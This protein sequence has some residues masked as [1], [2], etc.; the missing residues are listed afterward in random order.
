MSLWR[1]LSHGVRAL[2]GGRAADREVDEE[3]RQFLDES[4]AELE[5]NGL[6][7]EE[8]ARLARLRAGNPLAMREEVRASGWEHLV[9]TTVA[10]LRYG[11]RRLWRNPGFSIVTIATLAIGI[12]SATAIVSVALPVFVRTLPFPHADRIQTIWDQND[13]RTRAEIAFG[14]FLELQERSVTF[15]SMAVS[16]SWQPTLSGGFTPERLE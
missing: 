14:N 15:E 6:T 10:D 12:G 2:I 11:L 5:R 7:P 4:A 9:E 3:L 1:Q 16:R 13:D 8:A